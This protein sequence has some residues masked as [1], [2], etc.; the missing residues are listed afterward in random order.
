MNNVDLSERF[1][2]EHRLRKIPGFIRVYQHRCSV[3]D[4]LVILYGCRNEAGISRLGLS[5]S[6]KVGNA[7][8]RN[9]WKRL[10]REAFRLSN[11]KLPVAIDLVVIPKRGGQPCLASLV[12][13]LGSLSWEL[14]R[15]LR[16]KIQG[17]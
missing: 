3:S 15:R 17:R 11:Q 10:L 8:V 9:R 5:V 2:K 6:R 1:P 14:D 4:R 7:V 13:S 12:N 16:K